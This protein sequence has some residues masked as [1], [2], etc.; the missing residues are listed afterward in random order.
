VSSPS[1]D[2]RNIRRFGLIASLFFGAL[3]VLS[4]WRGNMVTG[5]IFSG[6]ALLGLG[7]LIL[8]G[9]LSPLYRG[10]LKTTTLI[11]RLMTMVILT[12]VYF[13]VLTPMAWLKRCFGGRPL[14]ISPDRGASS[15]W[16][17]RSEPAQPRERFIK[18][19]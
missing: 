11:G 13:T 19:Y 9:P 1:T 2:I 17:T 5:V 14:P 6:L 8:P 15:Y 18:R 16:V 7:F 12:V 3:L 10:W 4:L